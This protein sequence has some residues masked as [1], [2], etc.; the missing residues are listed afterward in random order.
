MIRTKQLSEVT[1][2]AG[3]GFL[4]HGV[5]IALSFISAI[6]AARA[7]DL[8]GYG[9]YMYAIAWVNILVLAA[10]VGLD[11]VAVRNISAYISRNQLGFVKGVT[12]RVL[13][14]T[15]LAS[16][17][18]T[19]FA[20]MLSEII[21]PLSGAYDRPTIM[22]ALPLIPLLALLR[23]VQ[24][25]SRGYRSIFR[26]KAPENLIR[27]IILILFFGGIL[28][29]QFPVTS[30]QAM[31]VHS[32]IACFALLIAFLWLRTLT[33]SAVHIS[34]PEFETRH[35]YYSALPFTIISGMNF[36]LKQSDIIIV[37]ILCD[38]SQLA[39]YVVASRISQLAAFGLM[40]VN[41][42]YAPLSS[43]ASTQSSTDNLRRITRKA[44]LLM[45][46]STIPI[47]VIMV[48]LP[49]FLLSMFGDAYIS[50]QGI[51]LVL[52]VGH[53][54]NAI[55]GPV[56]LLLGMTGNEKRVAVVDG[57]S[58]IGNIALNIYLISHYGGIGAAYA[59]AT[60]MTFRNVLLTIISY[61]R[62]GVTAT[63]LG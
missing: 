43:A 33:P 52:A 23:V 53:L 38:S 21:G 2:G 35:W 4:I 48:S 15:L 26:A 61:Q 25:L 27:P 36:L 22:L 49:E 34:Y 47:F 55:S 30:A 56:G 11:N 58:V 18:A 59:T 42:I 7:L 1:R 63:A 8:S 57:I 28:Y 31:A 6:L 17:I 50:G 32:V 16:A 60:A 24:G 41:P 44:S 51:L 20:L 3:K 37:G 9:Q 12:R 14:G 62:L 10:K 54:I 5:T 40:A 19:L 45:L 13:Q 39:V 29:L 46:L